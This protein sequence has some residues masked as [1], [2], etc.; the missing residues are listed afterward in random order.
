MAEGSGLNARDREILNDIIRTFILSGEPVSSRSVAKRG[1]HA[2]SAAT[3]RNVMADL[4]DLGF[5]SQPHISAGRVPTRNGYHFYIDALMQNRSITA[6]ARRTIDATLASGGSGAEEMMSSASQLLSE[7]THQIGI[8]MTPT[9]GRSTLRAIDFVNL[10]G[11]KVLCVLVGASGFV[12]NKVIETPEPIA[13]RDL[14]R[15]SNYLTDHFA[16]KTLRE[17]RDELI[18]LM[19]EDRTKVDLLLGRAI[20]LAQKAFADKG[21]PAVLVEGTTAILNQPELSDLDRIRRL[22]GTFSDK[23]TLVRVLNQL[24]EGP[25]V[26]VVIGKDSDLTSELDFSLV[27]TSY[28]VG[29]RSVGKLGIFGPSRMDYQRVIPIVEYFGEK[30]GQ[31]L[32][33]TFAE[34]SDALEQ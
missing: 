18:D 26:R 3:I 15:I 17:I 8:V 34:G 5:L 33:R 11:S 22:L 13:R 31:A 27:A 32:E 1:K 7:L 16:G 20:E 10:S 23:A 2:L 14:V 30:I 9:V 12:D 25:G 28:D 6:K 24:I 21:T 19:A 4:E 29:D